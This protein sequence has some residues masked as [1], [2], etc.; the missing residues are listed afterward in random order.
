KQV[1]AELEGLYADAAEKARRVVVRKGRENYLCLLNLEDAAQSPAIH[2]SE[3]SAVA[4]GLVLRWA[5]VTQ[6][7]DFAGRDFPGWLPG[8]VGHGRVAGL[9]D[10]RG[11]CIY[12]AC[13]HFNRCFVEKSAR[14]ARRADIVI[15]NHALVM[16]QAAAAGQDD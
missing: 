3:R 11:E 15:A 6:D 16:H 14:R 2:T 9:S 10:R 7:G 12:S 8:L 1:D 13:P 4:L 5:A